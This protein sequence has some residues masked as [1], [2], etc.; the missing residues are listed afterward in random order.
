M[1]TPKPPKKYSP[2]STLPLPTKP[3]KKVN[4][5][6][7]EKLRLKQFGE[8]ID[9]QTKGDWIRGMVCAVT[10]EWGTEDW[11]IDPAHVGSPDPDERRRGENTRGSGATERFI[12]PLKREV[13]NDFDD[14]DEAT[15]EK[16]W[17]VS[18]Q[19]VREIAVA[20]DEEY[21]AMHPIS[22]PESH[23]VEEGG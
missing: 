4:Y 8:P 20:L 17:G 9:G 11:P 3:M 16:R 2:F 18:K 10:G 19:W 21:R 12:A 6:R 23:S 22:S 5:A 14:E 13:H 7:R 1:K 15:F